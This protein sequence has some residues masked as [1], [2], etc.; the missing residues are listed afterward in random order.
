M[1]LSRT[2]RDRTLTPVS[3]TTDNTC[4]RQPHR[5]PLALAAF[6]FASSACCAWRA[7]SSSDMLFGG[8]SPSAGKVTYCRLR[9]TAST[10]A[11]FQKKDAE[12]MGVMT[13]KLNLKFSMMSVWKSE[14]P[15]PFHITKHFPSFLVS[16]FVGWVP[17][18]TRQH[19]PAHVVC[20]LAVCSGLAAAW[21]RGA[22]I[23]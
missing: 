10:I 15:E 3:V 2:S 8:R 16:L 5:L 20:K 13:N 1:C 19:D 7:C 18:S 14:R 21:V 11:S 17:G 12:T 23:A 4:T 9:T 6:R 22:S